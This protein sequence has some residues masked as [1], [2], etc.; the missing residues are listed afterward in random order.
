MRKLIYLTDPSFLVQFEGVILK[1]FLLW[2]KVLIR[3]YIGKCCSTLWIHQ[4]YLSDRNGKKI[5]KHLDTKT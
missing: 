3:D 1:S 5:N 2:K 4:S